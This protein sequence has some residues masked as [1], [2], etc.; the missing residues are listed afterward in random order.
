MGLYKEMIYMAVPEYIRKVQRPV[1]TIVD[2][3]GRDGPNRYAVRVRASV[4]YVKGST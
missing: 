1:N 2:D 4:R 3:N